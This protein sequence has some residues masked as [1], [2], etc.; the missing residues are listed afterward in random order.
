[1]VAPSVPPPKPSSVP[2]ADRRGITIGRY[3][4]LDMLAQGGMGVVYSAFDA[5][6]DRK[7]AIK[8]LHR[9]LA[10]GDD[11]G[12]V[13]GRLLREAQAMAR[14]SHPNVVTIHDVGMF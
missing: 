4:V 10:T 3:V 9:H 8:V 12:E 2:P 6:L 14:L 13:Q 5:Q 7:V 1:M 11:A